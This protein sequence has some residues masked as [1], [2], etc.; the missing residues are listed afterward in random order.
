ML[1]T[2]VIATVVSVVVLVVTARVDPLRK[3]AGL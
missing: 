3:A 2:I 1:K